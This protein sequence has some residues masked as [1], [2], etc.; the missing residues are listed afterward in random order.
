MQKKK[1]PGF[2]KT[3]YATSELPSTKMPSSREVHAGN[4]DWYHAIYNLR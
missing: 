3:I 1:I 2:S 4:P